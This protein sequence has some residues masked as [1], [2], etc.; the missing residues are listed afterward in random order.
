[1]LMHFF[2][3]LI[4]IKTGIYTV[5]FSFLKE[6]FCDLLIVQIMGNHNGKVKWF[7]KFGNVK[8]LIP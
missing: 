3:C 5:G 6:L 1:M 2:L 4:K 8:L 7:Y